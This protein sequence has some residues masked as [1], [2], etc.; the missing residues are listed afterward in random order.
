MLHTQE[1]S[2]G[3][4]KENNKTDAKFTTV[5]ISTY[6]IMTFLLDINYVVFFVTE[7]VFQLIQ[8]INAFYIHKNFS[9]L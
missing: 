4:M 8:Y 1:D 3:R 5:A 2:A 6:I 9:D 7:H